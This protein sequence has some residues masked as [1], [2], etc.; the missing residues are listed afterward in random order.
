MPW[1]QKKDE[2]KH[3][4]RPTDLRKKSINEL[5]QLLY[6]QEKELKRLQGVRAIHQLQKVEPTA[7][8]LSGEDIPK[9][10]ETRKNVARIKTILTEK[11]ETT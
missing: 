8:R 2:P 10:Q 7:N 5:K 6:D 3:K 1:F 11:G 9:L 4:I